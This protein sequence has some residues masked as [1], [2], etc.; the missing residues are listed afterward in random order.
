MLQQIRDGETKFQCYLCQKNFNTERGRSLHLNSCRRKHTTNDLNLANNTSTTAS[1][2]RNMRTSN[3]INS[4]DIELTCVWGSHTK[5]DLKQ[6][7]NAIYE[8]IVF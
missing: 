2:T 3:M 1:A 8:E 4:Q 6:V 5:I 7:V